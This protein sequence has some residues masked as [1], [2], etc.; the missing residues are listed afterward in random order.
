VLITGVTGLIGGATYLHLENQ[1]EKYDL[2]GLDRSRKPSAR[3][4][5][6]RRVDIPHKRLFRCDI[7]KIKSVQRAVEGMDVVV[8]LAADP[9]GNDWDS[10][11]HNNLIGAYNV[12]E[13]SRLAK[14]RRIVAASSAQVS[15]GQ[16]HQEPY[17]SV[18][19][20]HGASIPPDFAPLSTQVPPEPRNLYACSKV[21][22]ESLARTYAHMHG[23]S[24]VALRIG[25]V[26]A[27]D[28]PDKSAAGATVWCS[29][30]DVAQMIERCIDA[31]ADLR[32]D[33]LYCVSKNARRWVDIERAQQVVGYVPKDRAED[34][35]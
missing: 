15:D 33:V 28:R 16:R 7:A 8:H 22:V 21:W 5:S 13:A 30:R 4:P 23:M 26:T 24:C 2:Y 20:A 10:V 27:D 18:A 19:E 3:T 32:F 6:G 14:V 1:P 34:H 29:Q 35:T 31:P 12:F 17:R 9:D 25:W 11:L